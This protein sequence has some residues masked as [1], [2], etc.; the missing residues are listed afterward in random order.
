MSYRNMTHSYHFSFI[1]IIVAAALLLTSCLEEESLPLPWVKS[2]ITTFEVEG[3]CD[4]TGIEFA[5]AQIDKE[6]REISL[7][8]NDQVDLARVKLKKFGVS[9]N[10]FVYKEIADGG[11]VEV[12][13][14]L[15]V[16]DCSKGSANLLLKTYQ[17]FR[18]KVNV[19]RIVQREVVLENQVGEAVIDPVNCNVVAY[20]TPEQK[21]NSVK[22]LKFMLGGQ[23]GRVYPDPTGTEVDFTRGKTYAVF[24]YNSETAQEWTIFVYNAA[25]TQTTTCEVFPHSVRAYVSGVMQN[26]TIPVVEYCEAGSDNWRVVVGENVIIGKSDYKAVID[27]LTAGADYLCRTTADGVTSP[28]CAF[29]TVDP[30]QLPNS[31]FDEWSTSD[32]GGRDLYQPWKAGDTPFWDTGNR[33]A[34]TVGQS[35]STMGTEGDRIFANLQSKYIV[36]KFAAGNIFAGKYLETDGTNGILS[37]GQP[38]SSYPTKLQFDYSFKTS[39]INKG[40]GKWDDSYGKY[41]SRNTYDNLLGQPD[42]CQVFVALI[43]DK[44]EEVYKDVTYPFVVRTRPS[45]LKLFN[46]NSDNVIAYGQMTKGAD[47]PAWTTETITLN[48]RHTDRKPKYIVVVAASSKFGD[49]FIGGSETLLKV[50]NLKLLY[51]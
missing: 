41:I 20:V 43:G 3:Q 44:D 46:P 18:W 37:F 42:T 21:L 26:G 11:L 30:L 15:P 17:E 10:A 50:D 23:H 2:E 12:T 24:E 51:E 6:N 16:L 35:N 31:S 25:S 39:T 36:I 19:E 29:H 14:T 8:V 47:V 4:A 32:V 40:G 7:Y 28:V 34:T 49:Y 1:K 48:Y 38:F 9:N 33:G 22:V 13:H 45:T 5:E 27:G